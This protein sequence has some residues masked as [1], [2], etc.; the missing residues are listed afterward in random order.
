MKFDAGRMENA[1]WWQKITNYCADSQR[2]LDS[3][4]MTAT[5]ENHLIHTDT[6]TLWEPVSLDIAP[7]VMMDFVRAKI[8]VEYF[9]QKEQ[10]LIRLD[11]DIRRTKIVTDVDENTQITYQ[12]E[13]LKNP[14]DFVRY[15]FNHKDWMTMC[16]ESNNCFITRWINMAINSVCRP[17]N[18]YRY[19]SDI[20]TEHF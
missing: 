3:D 8:D 9:I 4:S 7:C 11:W 18:H 6:N 19:D 13:L 10:L 2:M 17:K 5:I 20:S 14:S 15:Y 16:G 12:I 1:E